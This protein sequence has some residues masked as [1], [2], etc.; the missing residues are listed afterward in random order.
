MR[1]VA[2]MA[3]EKL[4]VSCELIDLQTILPWDVETVCKVTEMHV[5]PINMVAWARLHLHTTVWTASSEG[6][7]SGLI[8]L[9]SKSISVLKAIWVVVWLDL[10]CGV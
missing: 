6:K 10:T 9:Y 1:E 7:S 2:I 8:S 4:G 5:F 3:Q